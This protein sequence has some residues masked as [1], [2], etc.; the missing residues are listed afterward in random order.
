M[1]ENKNEDRLCFIRQGENGMQVEIVGNA[2]I[3]MSMLHSALMSHVELRRMMM[4]VFM[5]IMKDD[6]FMEIVMN[7]MLS[8][9]KPDHDEDGIVDTE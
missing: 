9:L 5:N 6:K 3:L 4:P 1:E 8:A 2:N 7:D